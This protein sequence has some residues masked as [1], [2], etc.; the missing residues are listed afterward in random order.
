VCALGLRPVYAFLFLFRQ[1]R[2]AFRTLARERSA[3]SE[4]SLCEVCDVFLR[5]RPLVHTRAL[6]PENST[7]SLDVGERASSP[8]MFRL[9]LSL[10]RLSAN[11]LPPFSLAFSLSS[12]L[13]CPPPS[14][15][16]FVMIMPRFSVP[17]RA[18][19]F[20]ADWPDGRHISC[21]GH[22]ESRDV[23]QNAREA[24]EVACVGRIVLATSRM[25]WPRAASMVGH[26]RTRQKCEYLGF[27]LY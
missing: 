10:L 1:R 15:L 8:L 7:S 17:M 24:A 6:L 26:Q 14:S 2:V 11:F 25:R 3:R 12:A 22:Q 27:L 13:P 19:F 23:K 20:M 21:E 9:L 5:L 18:R 16:S 4:I